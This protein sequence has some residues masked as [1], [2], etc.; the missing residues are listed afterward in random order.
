MRRVVDLAVNGLGGLLQDTNQVVGSVLVVSPHLDDAA[1]SIGA[2][3]ACLSGM[4]SKVEVL[5]L[6][7]GKPTDG[8][9]GPAKHF[10]TLCCQPYD[11]SAILVR[12]DEDR[13]AIGILGARWSHG[14]FLDA[15]YRKQSNGQWLC[16]H[17]DAMF[18]DDLA[19]EEGLV[20][21]LSEYISA[22]CDVVGPDVILTCSANGR[23][24]DHRHAFNSSAAAA[25]KAEKPLLAWE[26]LPYAAGYAPAPPR[27]M[28]SEVSAVSDLASWDVKWKAI[29]AYASQV[30][31]LWG[32]SDWVS[33]LEW[34]ARTR[35]GTEPAELFWTVP[36]NIFHPCERI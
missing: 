20:D 11:G 17:D 21:E 31:M 3:L 34:H 8:L 22:K 12:Q 9:S 27:P 26:D 16:R 14:E 32:D 5:T 19:D 23:H 1:L 4:G 7:A 30:F 10:H 24:V 36:G 28:L 13:S 29:T 6:F 35:G 2:T 15:V 25:R 33:L 18:A